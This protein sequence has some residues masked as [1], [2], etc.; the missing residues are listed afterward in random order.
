MELT[1]LDRIKGRT[2]VSAAN[3]I[4]DELT[5]YLDDGSFLTI[6]SRYGEPLH[7]DLES[8]D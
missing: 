8:D 4:M 6:S 1:T 7:Y 2:I 5:L 3:D